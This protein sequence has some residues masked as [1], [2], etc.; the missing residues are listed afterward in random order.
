MEDQT[1]LGGVQRREQRGTAQ[2]GHRR[3]RVLP[4]DSFLV[5]GSVTWMA[6]TEVKELAADF[7]FAGTR[8]AAEKGGALLPAISMFLIAFLLFYMGEVMLA[9][10]MFLLAIFAGGVWVRSKMIHKT[11]A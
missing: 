4:T 8:T 1:R 9:V 3:G 10:I 7:T 11:T 6:G 2:A 5:P